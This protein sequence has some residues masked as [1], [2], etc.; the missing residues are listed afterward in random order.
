M[1]ILL[2]LKFEIFRKDKNWVQILKL[3]DTDFERLSIVIEGLQ[4]Y[5]VPLP[6]SQMKKFTPPPSTCGRK[7][8][9]LRVNLEILYPNL[10][11]EMCVGSNY[12]GFM[13]LETSQ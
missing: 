2:E 6:P 4:I 12:A 7:N 9:K 8:A 13:A 1:S 3:I 10:T 11:P 5:S